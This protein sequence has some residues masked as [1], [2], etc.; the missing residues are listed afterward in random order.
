MS[1]ISVTRALAQVKQLNDRIQRGIQVPF[2]GYTKGGK[3]QSNKPVA[4]VETSFKSA[5]QSVT[6]LIAQRKALKSA[7]VRSNAVTEVEIAGVKM[8]VAEAIER[9][10]S[11]QLEQAL[12]QTLRA[13]Q[14][15]VQ[16]A[17]ERENVQVTARLD[18][19]ISTTVGKDRKVDEAE[20]NAI[21][22]PFLASNEAKVLD[23]SDLTAKIDEMAQEIDAFLLEVDFALSEKNATTLIEA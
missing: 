12:L 17:V 5:L 11:I 10:T 20:L 3:H 13:Q 6:D 8:T 14:A 1:K 7:I 4:E 18:Q 2:V 19:L 22:L 21:K 23:P 15:Q 9:K 16:A